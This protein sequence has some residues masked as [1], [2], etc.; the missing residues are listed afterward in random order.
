[1]KKFISALKLR[2]AHF[3]LCILCLVLCAMLTACGDAG[4]FTVEA[5]FDNV[6]SPTLR[7]V[8]V[9]DSGLTNATVPRDEQGTIRFA[10]HSTEPTLLVITG[11][12]G[13]VLARAIVAGGDALKVRGDARD[14][15]ALYITGNAATERW[16]A[17]RQKQD[18]LYDA[19]P[20]TALDD[21][22]VAYATAHPSDM[23]SA[24]LL[25]CDHSNV[26]TDAKAVGA[27]E[28]LA[29]EARPASLAASAM[30]IASLMPTVAK[31]VDELHLFD[32][33]GKRYETLSTAGRRSV[34]L[35]W[36]PIDST[37]KAHFAFLDNVRR[38]EASPLVTDINMDGDSTRWQRA[39]KP[40]VERPWR[41][42]WSPTGPLEPALEPL[43][44]RRTPLYLVTDT[45][46]TIVYRGADTTAVLRSL[47]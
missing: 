13:A 5:T 15:D 17:F 4:E 11:D 26:T 29:P 7:I 33:D 42:L 2:T 43:G 27:L 14:G 21:S 28:A 36:S 10:G 39:L 6:E 30:T 34:L 8:F 45:T 47:R 16:L 46:G 40:F 24:A 18:P 20:C 25:I 41:H 32:D 31:S 9:G 12:R 44:V 19:A 22:I 3:A 37:F 38:R 23:A 1:M 35:F